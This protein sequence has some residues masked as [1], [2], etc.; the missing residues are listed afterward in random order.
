VCYVIECQCYAQA[1]RT[2]GSG[3]KSLVSSNLQ[4]GLF[5]HKLICDNKFIELLKN[6]CFIPHVT[7][8]ARF[9]IKNTSSIEAMFFVSLGEAILGLKCEGLKG[10]FP[11]FG[12]S[13]GIERF[14]NVPFREGMV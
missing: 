4:L 10:S 8:W 3:M 1:L 6:Q 2:T 5:I 12:C 9:V 14:G 7:D 13:V 11:K